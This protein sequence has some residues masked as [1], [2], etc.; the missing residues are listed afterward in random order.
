MKKV[1]RKFATCFTLS[2]CVSVATINAQILQY[3]ASL[4]LVKKGID[5]V[6]Y[7]HF[8]YAHEALRKISQFS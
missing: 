1:F 4:N 7:T 5:S 2:L 3:T 8:V 6:Y